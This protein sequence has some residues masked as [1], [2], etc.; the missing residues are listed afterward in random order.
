MSPRRFCL[1]TCHTHAVG[2]VIHGFCLIAFV[3]G[4][5]D[6]RMSVVRHDGVDVHGAAFDR[7]PPPRPSAG[8]LPLPSRAILC[9][10]ERSAD[11]VGC[12]LGECRCVP[13]GSSARASPLGAPARVHRPRQSLLAVLQ[14]RGRLFRGRARVES[15]RERPPE[16]CPVTCWSFTSSLSHRAI[17]GAAASIVCREGVLPRTLRRARSIRS[18]SRSIRPST[19]TGE[20]EGLSS[21]PRSPPH[22]S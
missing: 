22:P 4:T 9:R 8:L 15:L 6:G 3:A 5:T 16:R 12:I 11:G 19:V 18:A 13:Q 21:S 10:S 2:E 7:L 17:R 1:L 14:V 20:R